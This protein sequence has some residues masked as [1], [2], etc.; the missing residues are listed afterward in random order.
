[1]MPPPGSSQPL[2]ASKEEY[3]GNQ[4]FMHTTATLYRNGMLSVSTYSE[5]QHATEALTGYLDIVCVDDRG[6]QHWASKELRCTT[7]GSRIDFFTPSRGTD[8]FP[9]HYP[10]EVG[11]LPVRLDIYHS[12]CSLGNPLA[13]LKNVIKGTKDVYDEIKPLLD[14]LE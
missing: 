6:R 14:Q 13:G 4:K 2:E 11:R 7:R 5:C 12:T 9:E 3:V 10:E 1:V 8:Y